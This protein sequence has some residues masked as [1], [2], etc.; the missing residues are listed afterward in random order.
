MATGA[1]VNYKEKSTQL[2]HRLRSSREKAKLA[3]MQTNGA[4][5]TVV[6]GAAAGFID[7]KYPHVMDTNFPTNAALGLVALA[8]GLMEAFD[9]ESH[10]AVDVGAGLLAYQA[11]KMAFEAAAN[12][13]AK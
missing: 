5:I 1:L 8:A 2:E 12:A 7:A 11:G 6:G 3:A 10:L 4:L 9:S 13:A